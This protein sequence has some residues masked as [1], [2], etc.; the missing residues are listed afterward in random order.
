M[1]SICNSS[2]ILQ[3]EFATSSL[4]M[5]LQH[6]LMRFAVHLFSFL[7]CQF[8]GNCWIFRNLCIIFLLVAVYLSILINFDYIFC[9]KLRIYGQNNTFIK[10]NAIITVISWKYLKVNDYYEL[11]LCK[12]NYIS[13]MHKCSDN[14]NV[15]TK[16]MWF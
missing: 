7:S 5:L 14:F 9:N 6:Y 8:R 4:L 15:I 2:S 13:L 11:M 10:V 16:L 12:R 3:I 1:K